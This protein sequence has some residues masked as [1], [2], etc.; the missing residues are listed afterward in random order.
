LISLAQDKDV[1]VCDF[2][3]WITLTYLIIIS[4]NLRP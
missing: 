4:R 2:F 1:S 3:M